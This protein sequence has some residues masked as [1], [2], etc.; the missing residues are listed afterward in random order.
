MESAAAAV[1]WTVGRW[2]AVVI[3]D[4]G[5]G[6]SGDIA[7]M[8]SLQHASSRA[9]KFYQRPVSDRIERDSIDRSDLNHHL[10]QIA[11]THVQVIRALHRK[12]I[13]QA[14]ELQEQ[15]IL[16]CADYINKHSPDN[17]WPIELMIMLASDLTR[18]AITADNMSSRFLAGSFASGGGIQQQMHQRAAGDQMKDR[19]ATNLTNLFRICAGDK[20]QSLDRSK[21]IGMLPLVN[22]LVKI[23]FLL[24]RLQLCM[25]LIRAIEN[26]G[27]LERYGNAELVPYRYYL[28][29]SFLRKGEFKQAEEL[30]SFAFDNCPAQPASNVALI[31]TYLVPL[32][33]MRGLAP[34]VEL[35]RQRVP[36][37]L[38]LI[39]AV[40]KGDFTML[41]KWMV[42]HNNVVEKYKL[43]VMIEGGLK[44]IMFRNV[45]RRLQ[46][47]FQHYIIPIEA[48]AK[49]LTMSGFSTP[50][51]PETSVEHAECLLVNLIAFN[52]VKGYISHK[53][54]KV[55]LA[56]QSNAFPVWNL[57]KPSLAGI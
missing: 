44:L 5:K 14:Y 38:D 7:Q 56:K 43:W 36:F 15:A 17:N 1:D 47:A 26:S 11:F 20:T 23:N 29:Q 27:L 32:R 42:Q 53:H 51:E 46:S 21:R 30:F 10:A 50:F 8:L 13:N 28:A 34:P 18:L 40:R 24:D 39:E 4:A 54:K 37:Y 41:D 55:V 35:T 25:P 49:A 2:L 57:E 33:L 12:D 45:L 19:A 48:Y 31:L 16:V 22:C 6:N 52:M 9:P 3:K